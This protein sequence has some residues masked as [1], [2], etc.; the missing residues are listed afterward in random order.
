MRGCP[1]RGCR[2]RGFLLEVGLWEIEG[3]GGAI[4]AVAPYR[5]VE[6]SSSSLGV[7]S[8]SIHNLANLQARSSPSVLHFASV[9]S[10]RNVPGKN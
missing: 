8:L 10:I 9:G 6:Q 4:G 7:L 5:A 1:M 2:I 3:G